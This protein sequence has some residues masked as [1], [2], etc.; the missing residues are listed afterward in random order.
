MCTFCSPANVTLKA[1]Y[2][3]INTVSINNALQMLAWRFSIN[4]EWRIDFN[5]VRI[6]SL[7][8]VLFFYYIYQ[9]WVCQRNSAAWVEQFHHFI[10][11]LDVIDKDRQDNIFTPVTNVDQSVPRHRNIKSFF[12]WIGIAMSSCVWPILGKLDLRI[13]RTLVEKNGVQNI[14]LIKIASH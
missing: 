3:Q 5:F 14:Y 6:C 10:L 2:R 7:K 4:N 9:L 11:P 12:F 13:L 1:P 8:W